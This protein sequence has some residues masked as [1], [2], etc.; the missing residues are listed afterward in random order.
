MNTFQAHKSVT[1]KWAKLFLLLAT[2]VIL[3]LATILGMIAVELWRLDLIRRFNRPPAIAMDGSMP[4]AATPIQVGL[5]VTATP[6]KPLPT[7]IPTL[8]A[9]TTPSASP[10]LVNSSTPTASHNP[11]PTETPW[12]PESARIENIYGYTQTLNLTCESRSAVDWARYFGVSIDELEFFNQLPSSDNPNKGFVGAGNDPPGR[13]PPY[14]YG[15]HAAPV[16]AL[17]RAYGLPA[18]DH[19]NFSVDHLKTELASGRPVIVWVIGP[20]L[21]GYSLIYVAQDGEEVVVAPNEHTAIVIGYDNGG[22]TILDG[23]LVYWRRWDT[24][25]ASFEVLGNMAITFRP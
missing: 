8:T 21:P 20:T 3:G 9:T 13:T 2:V 10:T 24:F 15:V 7:E 11:L 19:T 25:L 17:L 22:V 6:F 4:A 1:N 14:S 18:E 5:P 23:S 16:A 12:P